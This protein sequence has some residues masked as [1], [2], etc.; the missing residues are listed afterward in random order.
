MK[1]FVFDYIEKLTGSYHEGGGLVIIAEDKEKAI[2][3]VKDNKCIVI[4]EEEWKEVASF[5]LAGDVESK[6]WAM[7]DAGCC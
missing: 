1:I 7:Q 5:D 2:E 3:L 4:T 6:Y